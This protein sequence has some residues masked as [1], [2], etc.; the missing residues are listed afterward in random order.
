MCDHCNTVTSTSD[1]TSVEKKPT[2]LKKNKLQEI[3]LGKYTCPICTEFMQNPIELPGCDHVF[4]HSC[5]HSMSY[6]KK[7]NYCALCRSQWTRNKTRPIPGSK[8]L[9]YIGL[10]AKLLIECKQCKTIVARESGETQ[11]EAMVRHFKDDECSMKSLRC[12]CGEK[13][14]LI[15]L[16]HHVKEFSRKHSAKINT[17]ADSCVHVLE[18]FQHDFLNS[19]VQNEIRNLQIAVSTSNKRNMYRGL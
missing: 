4:C 6:R 12:T 5:I 13:V 14:Q 3:I 10:Q 16:P 11:K 9:S 18:E 8:V 19:N 7:I 17:L 15:M 2:P 1:A